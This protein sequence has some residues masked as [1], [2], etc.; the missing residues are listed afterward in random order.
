MN[1]KI[2]LGLDPGYRITG[3]GMI[4]YDGNEIICVDNGYID[5]SKIPSGKLFYLG[6]KINQL[7]I[8]NKINCAGIEDVFL[9]D[10]A[11]VLIKLSQAKGVM[12]YQLESKGIPWAEYSPKTVKEKIVGT[13]LATKD[14]MQYAVHRYLQKVKSSKQDSYDALGVALC[15]LYHQI[16]Q[17]DLMLVSQ[18]TSTE[19]FMY[20]IIDQTGMIYHIWSSSV[21]NNNNRLFLCQHKDNLFGFT[22]A[23]ERDIF[24]KLSHLIRFKLALQIISQRP[25]LNKLHQIRGISANSAFKIFEKLGCPTSYQDI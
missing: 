21:I 24:I 25:A 1:N 2:I 11:Q 19:P 20:R 23:Q 12:L 5:T 16:I 18:F 22:C 6:E 3:Y 9:R 8:Q 15:R 4:C 14:Q 13:A 10:N 17:D 7:I